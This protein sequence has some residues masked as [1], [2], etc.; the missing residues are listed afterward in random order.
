MTDQSARKEAAESY[1]TSAKENM[2][3]MQEI[4]Q[5]LSNANNTED[6][7]AMEDQDE[8]EDYME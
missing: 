8:L 2:R 3:K 4:T 1:E 6:F 5:M 7:D